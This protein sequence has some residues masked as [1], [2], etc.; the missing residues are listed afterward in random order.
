MFFLI[1]LKEVILR[2]WFSNNILQTIAVT[3]IVMF[4]CYRRGEGDFL[5]NKGFTTGCHINCINNIVTNIVFI[6]FLLSIIIFSWN[7]MLS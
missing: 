4:N 3:Q 7:C 5:D 2:C 6:Y 1:I